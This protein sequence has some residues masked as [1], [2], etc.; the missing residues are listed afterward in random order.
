MVNAS[1]SSTHECRRRCTPVPEGGQEAAESNEEIREGA[2]ESGQKGESS[3][4]TYVITP[5][6]HLHH[7]CLIAMS[8]H[9]LPQILDSRVPR[10]PGLRPGLLTFPSVGDADSRARTSHPATC[11]RNLHSLKF[12]SR[13]RPPSAVQHFPRHQ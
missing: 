6:L 12:T 7:P 4:Q 10:T 13:S 11:D 3:R 8:L 1:Q 9:D 2:A 5:V